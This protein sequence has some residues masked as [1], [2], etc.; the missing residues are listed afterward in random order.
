[1]FSPTVDFVESMEMF[2]EKFNFVFHSEINCVASGDGN[3][4]LASCNVTQ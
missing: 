1:M 2:L 4:Q 3:K